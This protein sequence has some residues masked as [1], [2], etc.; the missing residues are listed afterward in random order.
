MQI[1]SYLSAMVVNLKRLAETLERSACA[2]GCLADVCGLYHRLRG[3][4]GR[5]LGQLVNTCA[6]LPDCA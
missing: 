6:F 2:E 1:Q 5:F 3:A 4:L